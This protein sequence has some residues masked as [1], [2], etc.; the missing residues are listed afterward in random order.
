MAAV[1]GYAYRLE[2]EI[3]E[4]VRLRQGMTAAGLSDEA[5]ARALVTLRLFKRFCDSTQV[6]LIIAT[7]TSAV[8]DAQ[9]G[10]EFVRQ[11]ES[12]LGLPLRILDGEREA[13][14]GVLGTLNEVPLNDGYVLDIGG[15]SMQISRVLGRRFQQG[16]SLP[17]SGLALSERFI[18]KDPPAAAE[19][20][21]NPARDRDVFGHRGLA[22]RTQEER[23]AGGIGGAGRHGPRHRQDSHPPLG[24]TRS[25]RSTASS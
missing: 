4:V 22:G 20:R 2:D 14:Y 25:T 11:V 6:D 5:M 1:Q 18:R 3:R 13:F 12:G 23:R 21:C 16:T 15:G 9:N 24:P 17:F 19:T 7:A 10:A 8:R